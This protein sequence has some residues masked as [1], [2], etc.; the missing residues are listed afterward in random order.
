MENRA[1]KTM[2]ILTNLKKLGLATV[3]LGIMGSFSVSDGMA[4]TKPVSINCDKSEKSGEADFNKVNLKC[5]LK[6][7]GED[8]KD[9][10][11]DLGSA[12]SMKE[13]INKA[14][15]ELRAIFCPARDE[16]GVDASSVTTS[17]D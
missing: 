17:S 10:T 7:T 5:T 1:E 6:Y 15:D 14:K 9:V 16:N 4:R 13:C 12:S 11:V 8:G 3:M 2:K